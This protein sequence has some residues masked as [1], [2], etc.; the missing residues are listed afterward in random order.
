MLKIMVFFVCLIL[1]FPSWAE[2]VNYTIPV[3]SQTKVDRNEAEIQAFKQLLSVLTM[4]DDLKQY[5]NLSPDQFLESYHYEQTSTDLLLHLRFDQTGLIEA[6]QEHGISVVRGNRPSLLVLVAIQEA[7]DGW[8]VGEPTDSV[9][10]QGLQEQARHKGLTLF[11]PLMD[12]DD[13][14]T[15]S[16]SSVW[17]APPE[18]LWTTVQRYHPQG[19]L[20]GKVN[21][22]NDA[23]LHSSWTLDL[24]NQRYDWDIVAPNPAEM[25][26]MLMA[27]LCNVYQDVFALHTEQEQ[28]SIRLHVEGVQDLATLNAVITALKEVEG[29]SDAKIYSVSSHFATFDVTVLGNRQALVDA[30]ALNA[31]FKPMDDNQRYEW[32]T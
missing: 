14:S 28:Q 32:R 5:Q 7:K 10:R 17:N 16:F 6:L 11:F 2:S 25:I 31:H 13:V 3:S 24:R 15:L 27:N 18:R 4:R 21:V 22:M 30:L 26:T 9:Y 23:A 29:V 20:V 1:A 12:L 8:V 19:V